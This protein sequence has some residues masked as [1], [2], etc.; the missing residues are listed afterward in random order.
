MSF[1]FGANGMVD[2]DA[3]QVIR[4]LVASDGA[5]GLTQKTVASGGSLVTEKYDN[6]TLTYVAAGNGVGEIET[7]T[8]TLGGN[9]VA[10]LTLTYNASNK[11]TNVARS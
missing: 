1:V 9:P 4:S 8:Y 2:L 7:V 10:V 11:L 3:D 5:G 6:M